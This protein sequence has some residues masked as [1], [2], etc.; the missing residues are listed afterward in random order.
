MIPGTSPIPASANTDSTPAVFQK[1]MG[2]DDFLKLLIAQ[3]AAQDPLSPMEAQDFSAQLAQFSSL[4]QITQVNANLESIRKLEESLSNFSA[5]N[6]IGKLVDAP[7]NSFDFTSGGTKVLSYNL[8]QDAASVKIE[9]FDTSG[10]KVDTQNLTN[11][12]AGANQIIWDGKDS[13]GKALNSGNYTFQVTAETK[14]GNFVTTSTFASGLVTDVVFKDNK[15][16]ALVNG[17]PLAVD[18]LT[19]ISLNQ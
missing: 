19:R 5:I 6:L 1:S 17:E 2:K 10:K 8:G 16:F 7:G 14:T 15:A 13:T 3:L 12:L 9:I 4:E 11:Q 18:E